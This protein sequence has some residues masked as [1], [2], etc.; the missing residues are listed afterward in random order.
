MKGRLGF[1]TKFIIIVIIQL[2][3][4]AALAGSK[5]FTLHTGE[6]ILLKTSPIDP[7]SLFSGDYVMLNYDISRINLKTVYTDLDT[8]KLQKDFNAGRHILVNRQLQKAYVKL[9]K[10]DGAKFWQPVSVTS[11]RPEVK[12][13]EVVIEGREGIY[14]SWGDKPIVRF[15]YGIESYYVPEGTGLDI[16]RRASNANIESYVE[17]AVDRF[18]N[19]GIVA[20]F[21]DGK[22]VSGTF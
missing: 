15:K 22:K 12:K 6:V 1:R 9:V 7:R 2:L 11:L 4:L 10:K 13:G 20:I 5:L 14:D 8:E 21:E 18:G 16:E 19:I 17:V 3:F